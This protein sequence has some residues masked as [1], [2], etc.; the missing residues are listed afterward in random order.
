[1]PEDDHKRL[2]AAMSI[3]SYKAD[4]KTRFQKST[5]TVGVVMK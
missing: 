1:M 4:L 2:T 3:D 5:E